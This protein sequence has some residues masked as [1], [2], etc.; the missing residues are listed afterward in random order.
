MNVFQ[1]PIG[2]YAPGIMNVVIEIPKGSRKRYRYHRKRRAF[3]VDYRLMVS[4]PGEYGWIPETW[5]KGGKRVN[6]VVLARK[7]TWG[8]NVCE[9]RPIGALRRCDGDHQMICV[10]LGEPRYEDLRDIRDLDEGALRRIAQFYE[11]FFPLDGW[12]GKAAALEFLKETHLTFVERLKKHG[13]AAVVERDDDDEF[14]DEFE[15]DDDDEDAAVAPSATVAPPPPQVPEEG[16]RA[17]QP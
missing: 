16:P 2:R 17:E 15:P 5:A 13:A 14:P 1:T 10:L 3:V 8:G 4:T 9:A 6:A 12:L 7:P 11:P